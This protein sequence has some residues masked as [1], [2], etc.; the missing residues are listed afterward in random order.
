MSNV[1]PC[2]FCGWTCAVSNC[3]TGRA[4]VYC[5][6]SECEY[7]SGLCDSPADA[8]L[9]H[10][11]LSDARYMEENNLLPRMHTKFKA[12]AADMASNVYQDWFRWSEQRRNDRIESWASKMTN[13]LTDHNALDYPDPIAAAKAV[14]ELVKAAR[15]AMWVLGGHVRFDSTSETPETRPFCRLA[16]ALK[17]FEKEGNDG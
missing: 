13:V 8:I 17:P 11:K 1:K 2:P 9:A 7:Q 16:A 10:N 6:S 4:F 12:V 15:D 3:N 5:R 14:D